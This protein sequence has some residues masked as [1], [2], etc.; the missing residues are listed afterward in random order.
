M[1]K[2]L[3][4]ILL[5]SVPCYAVDSDVS[6]NSIV[7]GSSI[8]TGGADGEVL[9]DNNGVLDSESGLFWNDDTNTLRLGG[10]SGS[11]I[12]GDSQV[13]SFQG[14][15][16]SN[17]ERVTLDLESNSN[18]VRISSDTSVATIDLVAMGITSTSTTDIGWS[19]IGSANQACNTTCTNACV[20]GVDN[21]SL[22]ADIVV[23]TDASAD[24]CLCAGGN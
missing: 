22:V 17:N 10:T 21:G 18:R 7:E 14:A 8:I 23:C 5:I 3:Y 13:I 12:S 11:H 24:E 9:Y 19:I 4:L 16:G 20:F 2:L 15:G 6:S 1:K